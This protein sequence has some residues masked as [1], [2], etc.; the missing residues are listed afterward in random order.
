MAARNVPEPAAD[1][2]AYRWLVS[3]AGAEWLARAAEVGSDPLRRAERLRRALSPE[4]VHLVLQQL[5]LRQRAVSSGRFPDAPRMFF[6]PRS[7]EQ[8]TSQV[9]AACKAR[10]FAPDASVADLCCGIGGDLTA[11]ARR[12]RVRGVERDAILALLAEAN[13]RALHLSHVAVATADAAEFPVRDFDA[14]HVDPDRRPQGRRTTKPELHEPSI[15]VIEQLRAAAPS[16]AVKLAPAAEVPSSWS[17]EAE[18]QWIGE[19]RECKQLVA[20]FGAL[21]RH[22]GRR[23]A[24]ALGGPE[25]APVTVVGLPD[26]TVPPAVQVGRYVYEPHAAIL[27]A[28]LSGALADRHDLTR[29]SP[30]CG[31]LTGDRLIRDP[32]MAAFEL[33]DVFPF[34]V[35]RLKAALRERRI[36]CLEVKKRGVAVDIPAL[37]RQLRVPGEEQRVLLLTRFRGRAVAMLARRVAAK[38]G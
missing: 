5:D 10:R 20:W 15:E 38:E 2:D 6:T 35:K 18:L 30:D 13:A 14:W 12:C 36:G 19:G 3:E 33:S 22:P 16:A 9:V 1:L 26:Q 21:A 28:G 11:L 23:V 37:Q 8:A 27:A 34:D 7:L 32:A 25:S 31:Y 24:S 29:V 4:Q 17:S